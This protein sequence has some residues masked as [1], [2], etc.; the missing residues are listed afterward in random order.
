MKKSRNI[1]IAALLIAVVSMAV[2]YA[3]LAQQLTITGN[4]YISADWD[5]E[6]TKIEMKNAVGATLHE[7]I[8]PAFTATTATFNVD[9]AYPGASAEF[10]VT[11]ENKGTIDA[12]LATIAGVAEA[13][14][15]APEEIKFTLS[16]IAVND[17][18]NADSSTVAKVKVEWVDDGTDEQE[19]PE[20]TSKTATITL[21]YKQKAASQS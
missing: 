1:I 7:D 3:A 11:I 14:A 5:V 21:N 16:G 2:G 9:L 10:D 13:N 4:A 17:N 15:L 8:A 12:Y 18:L 19:I 20:V 6:I